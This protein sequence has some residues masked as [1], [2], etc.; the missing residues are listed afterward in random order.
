MRVII[1]ENVLRDIESM[2]LV[3]IGTGTRD[4]MVNCMVAFECSSKINYQSPQ[5]HGVV[6]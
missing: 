2:W 3:M 4:N 1:M 6:T 5:L